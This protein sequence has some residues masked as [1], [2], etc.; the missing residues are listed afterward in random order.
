MHQIEFKSWLTADTRESIPNVHYRPRHKNKRKPV[1]LLQPNGQPPIE[2]KTYCGH[3]KFGSVDAYEWLLHKNISLVVRNWSK[4]SENDRVFA[5][6]GLRSASVCRDTETGVIWHICHDFRE[7]LDGNY[8]PNRWND[9]IPEYGDN[10]LNL[11]DAGKFDPIGI[12]YLVDYPLPLKFSFDRN[13]IYEALPASEVC[14]L[15]GYYYDRELLKE[16]V[17]A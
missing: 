6:V 2:E 10:P 14:P 3:G 12:R 11:I 9:V 17:P 5:R 7:I 4:M 15:H 16:K 1:F 8:F 13:A